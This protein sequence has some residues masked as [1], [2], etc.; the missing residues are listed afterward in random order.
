MR[1]LFLFLALSAP[2]QASGWDS[3]DDPEVQKMLVF[4]V[5]NLAIFFGALTFMLRGKIKD[6]LANRAG[7][8][9]RDID[10]SNKARKDATHR[11]EELEARL[12]SFEGE[13]TQMRE[14]AVADANKERAT[15]LAQAEVDADR[16]K[17]AAQR[18]IR[19]AT[20]RAQ[21]SLQREAAKLSIELA[22]ERLSAE[23]NA[24]DNQRLVGEFLSTVQDGEVANG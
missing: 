1:T 2:A 20:V 10:Q 14:D 17:E 12:S 21:A 7:Q 13:L 19:D 24:D 22:R 3:F 9:K 11:L 15:I 5:I 23:V 4:H 16:V 8:V 18:S 6:A